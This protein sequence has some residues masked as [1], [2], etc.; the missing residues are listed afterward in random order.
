MNK[1][2]LHPDVAL[3]SFGGTFSDN[4]IIGTMNRFPNAKA[5]DCF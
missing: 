4:Q 1:G 3:I 2:Q 5:F